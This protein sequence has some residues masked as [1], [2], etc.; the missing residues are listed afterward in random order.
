[1]EFENPSS[2]FILAA[3]A[4]PS[5]SWNSGFNSSALPLPLCFNTFQPYPPFTSIQQSQ[6]PPCTNTTNSCSLRKYFQ[7]KSPHSRALLEGRTCQNLKVQPNRYNHL[8]TLKSKRNVA[9]TPEPTVNE[10]EQ[11]PRN[12]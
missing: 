5:D 10:T 6:N 11:E 8:T 1:M 7:F 4:F 3:P 9:G 12:L 2:N